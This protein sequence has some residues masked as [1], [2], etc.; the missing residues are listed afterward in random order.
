[1]QEKDLLDYADDDRLSMHGAGHVVDDMPAQAR[2][3]R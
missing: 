3:L 1:M 2:A